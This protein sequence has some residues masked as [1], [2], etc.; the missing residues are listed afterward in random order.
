M[1]PVPIEAVKAVVVVEEA[2]D[3]EAGD[4][5]VVTT[6]AVPMVPLSNTNTSIAGVIEDGEAV[7]G[8]RP[9]PQGNDNKD[10]ASDD[11]V[12]LICTEP[13]QFYSV[14]SCNHRVC[15]VCSLRL[16][17]LY[18][19]KLCPMCKTDLEEVVFCADAEKPFDQYEPL[20]DLPFHDPP[21][22]IHFDSAEAYQSAMSLLR[23]NCPD[24]QCGWVQT[25]GAWA[26]LKRHVKE[27][28][29][30]LLCDICTRHKRIFTHE[31]T[32]YPPNAIR[33][34]KEEGD[35]RLISERRG[36]VNPDESF[37]KGH[38]ECGFCKERFF[39]TD[40][41]YS[42]CRHRH[43]ECFL[44][45]RRGVHNVYY[46]NYQ[47]LEDHFRA[48]HFAC[49]HHECL[50]R[51]FVVFDSEIDL[52]AHELEE[53]MGKQQR[54]QQ[55]QQRKLDV[56]FQYSDSDERRRFGAERGRGRRGGGQGREMWQDD[57]GREQ[58]A[59]GTPEATGGE[60][61][62]QQR[63]K[64]DGSSNG[65]ARNQAPGG[66]NLSSQEQARLRR[67][68]APAGPDAPQHDP[69]SSPPS[70]PADAPPPAA[71]R[72]KSANPNLISPELLASS[73]L[74]SKLAPMLDNRA[75]RLDRFRHLSASFTEGAVTADDY[76]E[77]VCKLCGGYERFGRNNVVNMLVDSCPA[78]TK[79]QD[80]LR[81]FRDLR[82][83]HAN[84]GDMSDDGQPA[85][86]RTLVIKASSPPGRS[87]RSSPGP[88]PRGAWTNIIPRPMTKTSNVW[89]KLASVGQSSQNVQAADLRFASSASSGPSTLASSSSSSPAPAAVGGSY[90]ASGA[91]AMA[92]RV[93]RGPLD[94][95][96]F[97]TLMASNPAPPAINVSNSK[98]QL[99][100]QKQKQ[101]QKDS[102]AS[103][104]DTFAQSLQFNAMDD[105]GNETQ[106]TTA[107]TTGNSKKKSK[108]ILFR[109]GL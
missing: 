63:G 67:I 93:V 72:Q 104:P 28:H 102:T 47:G 105:G 80:L 39:A 91:N 55:K 21:L 69:Q 3:E 9:I 35:V 50:E 44:C 33:I 98:Q 51:K 13:V 53:H 99:Q 81:A 89:N 32:L 6:R 83:K 61:Q 5:T 30:M 94:N 14:G 37:V 25:S 95:T 27:E 75:D 22:A 12:C 71:A 108:T 74:L 43:E 8:M 82:I 46:K 90:W 42:H 49:L 23:Y 1:L 100:Q 96:S 18:K 65:R 109:V 103:A 45:Q 17:A 58:A 11:D 60:R 16:R 92:S 73:P 59:S 76:A 36:L 97:P 70:A 106:V 38:P 48:D 87:A 56:G 52:K 84:D 2:A 40:E 29:N 19:S 54:A 7:K 24:P 62:P 57:Q 77:A 79:Q 68:R 78:K 64:N 85:K 107:T 101:R 88:A 10:P 86:P 41:L 4:A 34:H 31:H 20:N 15:H 66:D 26:E